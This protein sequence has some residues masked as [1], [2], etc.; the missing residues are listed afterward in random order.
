MAEPAA[1]DVM[2][3]PPASK[4]RMPLLKFG[5]VVRIIVVGV[6]LTA[7]MLGGFLSVILKV[8][9][10]PLAEAQSMTFACWLLGHVLLA[11]NCRTEQPLLRW[12]P[13]LW[14]NQPMLLW[15]CA[16]FST[17]MLLAT[18][19][20]IRNA[21][22]VES[23]DAAQWFLASGIAVICSCW[24]EPIKWLLLLR[25]CTKRGSRRR[26]HRVD[27]EGESGEHGSNSHAIDMTQFPTQP[28]NR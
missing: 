17:F 25:T 24:L 10:I 22:S 7:C 1:P 14:R 12:P 8:T 4:N 3:K 16:A 21:L 13:L 15:L 26:Y 9:D 19:P 28:E 11:F 6:S 18:I 20:W 27:A 23:I 5:A 2:D